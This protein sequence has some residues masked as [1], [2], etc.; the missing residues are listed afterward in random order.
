MS[1]FVRVCPALSV[2][3]SYFNENKRYALLLFG[4]TSLIV[5]AM[6]R[7]MF[8]AYIKKYTSIR[9]IKSKKKMKYFAFSI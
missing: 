3:S 5:Y 1:G 8:W 4:M 7:K 6:F 9:R 2:F